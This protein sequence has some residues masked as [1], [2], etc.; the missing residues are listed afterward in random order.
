[1]TDIDIELPDA[2]GVTWSVCVRDR[3][4]MPLGEVGADMPLRTASVGKVLLLLE[5]ARAQL[6]APMSD[7]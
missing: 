7:P 2:G 5:T 3:S 6:P 4:G 1:M